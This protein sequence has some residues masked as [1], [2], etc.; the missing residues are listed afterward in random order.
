MGTLEGGGRWVGHGCISKMRRVEMVTGTAYICR[1]KIGFSPHI[2]WSKWGSKSNHRCP[3]S[4]PWWQC[5][6]G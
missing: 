3:K 1:W 4:S 5:C 2:H 6:S